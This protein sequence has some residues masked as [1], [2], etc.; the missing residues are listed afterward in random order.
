MQQIVSLSGKFA[1]QYKRLAT[2]VGGRRNYHRLTS[3]CNVLLTRLMMRGEED[4]ASIAAV[5]TLSALQFIVRVTKAATS[6]AAI[7][8][9]YC[10]TRTHTDTTSN[11]A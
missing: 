7:L 8:N 10:N 6:F 11:P 2:S 9:C 3:C 5:C 1:G 4:F